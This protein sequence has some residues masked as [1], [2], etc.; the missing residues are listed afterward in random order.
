MRTPDPRFYLILASAWLMYAVFMTG[1]FDTSAPMTT[2]RWIAIVSGLS[3]AT[4]L[5]L[6][7]LF[8]RR[9]IREREQLRLAESEEH[10]DELTERTTSEQQDLVA[11]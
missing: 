2:P 9:Q 11:K 10:T 8:V 6:R 3:G 7:Y 5:S 4:L 1:I